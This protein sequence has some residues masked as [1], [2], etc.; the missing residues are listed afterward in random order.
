M[1]GRPAPAIGPGVGS[2]DCGGTAVNAIVTVPERALEN[3]AGSGFDKAL[4]TVYEPA[5]SVTSLSVVKVLVV[6]TEILSVSANE[7]V[8]T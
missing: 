1:D 5:E 3:G 4:Y 6:G 8:L 2:D 7:L